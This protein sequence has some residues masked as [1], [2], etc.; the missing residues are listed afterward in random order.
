MILTL[1]FL[2]YIAAVAVLAFLCGY[3]RGKAQA[4]REA[5]AAL[6]VLKLEIGECRKAFDRYR[7]AKR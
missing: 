4:F 3:Y 6:S 5:S 1:L 2:L 7:E